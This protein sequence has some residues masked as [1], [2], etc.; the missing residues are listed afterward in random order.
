M[1][2][3]LLEKTYNG[4]YSVFKIINKAV[5]CTVANWTLQ[6]LHGRS[7]EFRLTVPL[8]VSEIDWIEKENL[9][10]LSY[11]YSLFKLKLN[12]N[13]YLTYIDNDIK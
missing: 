8:N 7:P 11:A 2:K 5:K 4:K 13:Y 1:R 6:S 9:C 12:E 3:S 10:T